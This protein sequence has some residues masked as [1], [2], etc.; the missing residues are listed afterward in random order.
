MAFRH[1]TYRQLHH[2]SLLVSSIIKEVLKED[3]IVVTNKFLFEE[4]LLASQ[5]IILSYGIDLGLSEWDIPRS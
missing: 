2:K 3:E 4:R 5:R 1:E